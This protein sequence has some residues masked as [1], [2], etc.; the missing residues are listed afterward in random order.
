VRPLAIVLLLGVFIAFDGAN[1]L[2][3]GSR[4]TPA[5]MYYMLQ[6][7]WGA[8]L[9]GC[10]FVAILAQKASLWRNLGLLAMGI[11]MLEGTQATVCRLAVKDIGAVPRGTN[12][13]DFVTGW[14]L[15]AAM[16]TI[17]MMALIALTAA[18]AMDREA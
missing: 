15:G 11:G 12:L 13:C 14:P 18:W 7:A 8:L 1:W 3:D 4:F 10:L 6:G 17:Y 5:A 2:A 9:A 16:T